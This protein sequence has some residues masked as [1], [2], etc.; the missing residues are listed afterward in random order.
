M[1]KLWRWWQTLESVVGLA[2]VRADWKGFLKKEYASMEVFLRPTDRL[3]SS[4][5]C[6]EPGGE[7]CPRRIVV[8]NNGEIVAVCG[9]RFGSCRTLRLARSDAILREVDL[10][11]LSGSLGEALEFE[12]KT[13]EPTD[14]HRTWGLGSLSLEPAPARAWPVFLTTQCSPKELT[15]TIAELLA[16]AAGPFVVC[17]A[18]GRGWTTRAARMLQ[19][20]GSAFVDL[21]EAVGWVEGEGF[22]AVRPLRELVGDSTAAE[23]PL[24][25]EQLPGL[26][27]TRNGENIF[28]REGDLWL[29]VFEGQEGRVQPLKGH[30]YLAQLLASPDR[31]Y[32]S[33]QVV[34]AATGEPLTGLGTAGEI[35]DSRAIAEYRQQFLDLESELEEARSNNDGGRVEILEERREKLKAHLVSAAGLGGRVRHAADDFDRIRKSVANAIDR[36]IERFRTVHPPLHAHLMAS[37]KKG[38]Y[39]SYQPARPTRWTT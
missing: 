1:Q 18:T 32:H 28:R 38:Y 9:Q 23:I 33:P 11:R 6:P 26:A 3:A 2:V 17:G 5:S 39:L 15:R 10:A 12:A 20:T 37:V 7:G 4:Y 8:R 25:R 34:S 21:S 27:S 36:A 16:F 29:A 35:L 22:R 14:V 30:S 13:P 31:E 19:R 24:P